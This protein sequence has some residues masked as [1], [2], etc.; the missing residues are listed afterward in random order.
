MEGDYLL[1]LGGSILCESCIRFF[2]FV[3]YV[4][5]NLDKD[6]VEVICC[7]KSF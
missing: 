7:C 4:I 6:F 2:D 5:F 1:Y 3:R